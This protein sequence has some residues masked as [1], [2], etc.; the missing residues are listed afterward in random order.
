ME[1]KAKA[2]D[3][4]YLSLTLQ[5]PGFFIPKP[6]KRMQKVMLTGTSLDKKELIK[7]YIKRLSE[8]QYLIQNPSLKHFIE[9]KM[10][11]KRHITE[12]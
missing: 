9:K 8:Y 2:I 4:L 3:Q 11:I 10:D 6:S 1:Q 5:Y 7:G 12:G